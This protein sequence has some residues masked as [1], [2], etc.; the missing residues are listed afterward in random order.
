M[1]HTPYIDTPSDTLHSK[2][3]AY[4]MRDAIS[5]ASNLLGRT[6]GAGEGEKELQALPLKDRLALARTLGKEI[7]DIKE[8]GG[9][10]LGEGSTNRSEALKQYEK[11]QASL[12]SDA[13]KADAKTFGQ[14]C[15]ARHNLSP[16]TSH[17]GQDRPTGE[18]QSPKPLEVAAMRSQ[19]SGLTMGS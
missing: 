12:F 9:L 10:N 8:N 17:Y 3:D 14:I 18:A 13:E 16:N 6:R 7:K 5:G 19:G 1:A 2:G 4:E 11:L 15:A